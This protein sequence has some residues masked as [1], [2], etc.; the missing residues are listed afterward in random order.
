M[1][2]TDS[3]PL[4]WCNLSFVPDQADQVGVHRFQ[5]LCHDGV[6]YFVCCPNPRVA[7]TPN[8]WHCE[9]PVG[10]D[11]PKV[12]PNFALD[13]ADVTDR[14]AQEIAQECKT[15]DL[16]IV[17]H[18]SGG[19]DSTVVLAAMIRN[20]DRDLLSRIYVWMNNASYLENPYFYEHVI[21]PHGLGHGQSPPDWRDAKI[22]N[23]HPADALWG[24]SD[25]VEINRYFPQC[26]KSDPVRDPD[27][28][29]AWLDMKTS[30]ELSRWFYDIVVD[31]S[32]QAGIE[33]YTYEDFYWWSNFNLWYVPQAFFAV[34]DIP[35]K[36][37]KTDYQQHAANLVAWFH[38]TEY[39]CWSMASRAGGTKW[40]G[41]TR[42]YKGLAKDYIWTVDKNDYYR[43]YKTKSG[44]DLRPMKPANVRALYADGTIVYVDRAVDDFPR[45]L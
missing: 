17:V 39:Q 3:S 7:S 37:S 40:D 8:P 25:V 21:L 4:I 28:L 20:F 12:P 1:S 43:Q 30:P 6:Y 19:I 36:I 22:F 10:Y 29:L 41:T 23:G 33:L 44:S 18:W 11:I 31:S 27:R 14:R 5:K 38:T 13:F 2:K 9:Q 26:W 15:H 32:Q 34:S 24:Q 16:R 42:G 45:R 35:A